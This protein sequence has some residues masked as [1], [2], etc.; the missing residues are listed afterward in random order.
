MPL[1]LYAG[2]LLLHSGNLII[3]ICFLALTT[4]SFLLVITMLCR[5]IINY[6]RTKSALLKRT[7]HPPAY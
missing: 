4:I 2:Y 6:R 5:Y 1:G 3:A 7:M